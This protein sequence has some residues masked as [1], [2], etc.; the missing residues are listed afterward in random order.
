MKKRFSYYQVFILFLFLFI[1]LLSLQNFAQTPGPIIVSK[2]NIDDDEDTWAQDQSEG[3]DDGIVEQG[4]KIRMDIVL[5][6]NGTATATNVQAIISAQSNWITITRDTRTYDDI[7]AGKEK[8]S[9]GTWRDGFRFEVDQNAPSEEI[10]FTVQ[11]TTSNAG[12][13][14]DSVI[15][16][17]KGGGKR[18]PIEVKSF[19]IDDDE[20]S[21]ASDKSEGDNDQIP[22]QGERI[23]LPITLTNTG[24]APIF[25]VKVTLKS[26]SPNIVLTD[27]SSDYGVL[28]DN[29]PKSN[30]GMWRDG[31]HFTVNSDA[32]EEDSSSMGR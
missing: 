13:F 12:S 6:N 25:N 22:E 9:A 27:S 28:G 23:R 32:V 30:E 1:I 18:G 21:W 19:K 10:L 11:I 15:I 2:V 5:K 31:F 3:D 24:T 7:E 26:L 29:Q 8:N 4:E 20:D 14:Q 17:I 16:S